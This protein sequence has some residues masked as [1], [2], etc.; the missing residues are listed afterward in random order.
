MFAIIQRLSKH[1]VTHRVN[2]R[3]AF[4]D[5]ER[6]SRFCKNAQSVTLSQFD[7]ALCYLTA[8]MAD[9]T[10][11]EAK[12]LAAAYD[13]GTG[14]VRFRKFV[15]DIDP[16]VEP[17]TGF[18]HMGGMCSPVASP[19]NSPGGSV[20]HK[21]S[22]EASR[23]SVTEN[24]FSNEVQTF[25]PGV[26]QYPLRTKRYG[27]GVAELLGSIR[28]GCCVY[29]I[30]LIDHMKNIDKHAEGTITV[31]Q[32]QRAMDGLRCVRLSQKDLT[33]LKEEY[34]NMLGPHSPG[35][36]DNSPFHYTRFCNDVQPMGSNLELDAA[37]LPR[38][39]RSTSPLGIQ[40]VD[41]EEQA[42]VDAVLARLA[43]SLRKRRCSFRTCF[44]DYD[45][46]TKTRSGSTPNNYALSPGCISRTHF[47]QA[48]SA[49]GC[50]NLVT[51]QELF[52]LFKKYERKGDFN[53]IVFI[54]H[55]EAAERASWK[56]SDLSVSQG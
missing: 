13:D 11:K 36:E 26:C 28:N 25:G 56:A 10:A 38:D 49:M 20:A 34:A 35:R 2:V 9:F 45:R 44:E 3:G 29:N 40:E 19:L 51:D 17:I 22:K 7:E 43:D 12:I 18:V 27:E 23:R 50:G 53:Q 37:D 21:V 55:M 6:P 1:F 14:L 52:V 54:R 8:G 15:N 33:L 5:F 41:D 30:I 16:R 48:I 31:G 24:P 4:R 47:R 42:V 39:Q 46:L 32:F